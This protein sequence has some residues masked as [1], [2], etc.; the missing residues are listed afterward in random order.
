MGQRVFDFIPFPGKAPDN[1]FHT[2]LFGSFY[3][4]NKGRERGG[5]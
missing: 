4:L 3:F 1:T 2:K 5:I